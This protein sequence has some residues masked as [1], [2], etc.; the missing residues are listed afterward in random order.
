MMNLTCGSSITNIS[1]SLEHLKGWLENNWT[2]ITHTSLTFDVTQIDD[3]SSPTSGGHLLRTSGDI[4][5]SHINTDS[6]K[7]MANLSMPG[8]STPINV[9]V[10]FNCARPANASTITYTSW[11]SPGGSLN[12]K[13]NYSDGSS[14]YANSSDFAPGSNNSF[15]TNYTDGSGL[16]VQTIHADWVASNYS[17]LIWD[18]ANSTYAPPYTKANV[19]CRWNISLTLNYSNQSAEWLYVPINTTLG[20]GN[21]S[22]AGWLTVARD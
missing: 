3:T 8:N 1:R 21:S 22:Y 5:Y 7:D 6:S 12:G 11:T 13:I 18:E 17:L 9:S 4:N 16:W 10:W 15:A 14:S 20:Y 19:T 2:A